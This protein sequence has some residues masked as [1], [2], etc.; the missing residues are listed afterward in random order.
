MALSDDEK[1][2]DDSAIECVNENGIVKAFASYT[3][4]IPNNY[5]ARRS[6]VVRQ[7]MLFDYLLTISKS[8]FKDQTII[9]LKESRLDEGSI[10]CIVER[11]QFSIVQGKTFDLTSQE[12]YLLISSGLELLKE[13]SIGFHDINHDSSTGAFLFTE[14]NPLIILP[15]PKTPV[16]DKNIYDECNKSKSCIGIPEA[17]VINRNCQVFGAVI[18]KNGTYEFEMMS[19]SEFNNKY[20]LLR[21]HLILTC[22]SAKAAYIALALSFDDSMGGD[23]AIECVNDNNEVKAFTSMTRAVSN[24]YGARRNDVT[25][26]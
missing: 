17:C 21:K 25:F 13:N 22:F 18:V 7:S 16:K 12:F 2:G 8:L 11:A 14:D 24:D 19:P 23:S 9:S 15:F 26:K 5:G 1:M 6:E 4:A 10:Y 3:T 20:W